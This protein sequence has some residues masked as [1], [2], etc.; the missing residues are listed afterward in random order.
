MAYYFKT[1][2]SLERDSCTPK[3][4]QYSGEGGARFYDNVKARKQI[5]K[6]DQ[7]AWSCTMYSWDKDIS[8]IDD[9][10]AKESEFCYFMAVRSNYLTRRL[11]DGFV[12]EPYSPHRFSR[13]FGFYQ[14]RPGVLSH[15]FR[16]ASLDDGLK[17]W[18]ATALR[19]SASKALLP[20][21]PSTAKKLSSADYKDWWCQVYK[22]SFE[23]NVIQAPPKT[24]GVSKD[25]DKADQLAPP[26]EKRKVDAA[27]L[28]GINSSSDE[29]HWKRKR[30]EP[31]EFVDE[32]SQGDHHDSSATVTKTHGEVLEVVAEVQGDHRN[33]SFVVDE[34]REEAFDVDVEESSQDNFESIEGDHLN[35]NPVLN[36]KASA[37][38]ATKVGAKVG[39]KIGAKIG[40]I[41]EFNSTSIF[42]TQIRLC[43]K[44]IWG[45]LRDK[46]IRT[47]AQHLSSIEEEVRVGISRMKGL[48]QDFD[49][50]HLEANIGTL[51]IRAATYDKARSASHEFGESSGQQFRNN[52]ARLHML[53]LKK[54][55]RLLKSKILRRSLPS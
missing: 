10:N 30:V 39:A 20:C 40:A 24:N 41:S 21:V 6:G 5:H 2:F 44:N 55:K 42:D 46:I 8:F 11:E 4:V 48:S 22:R 53:E 35:A 3:M 19:K 14:V 9:E 1:H 37:I 50:S 23:E 34:A 18:D 49:L 13:Q 16:K 7:V 31:V 52:K 12:V 47:P 54:R 29:R 38:P 25:R 15:N 26:K 33:P 32:H 27:S 43:L 36:E 28:G 51:F 45:V 17:Y